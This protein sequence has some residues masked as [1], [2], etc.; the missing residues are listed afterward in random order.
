MHFPGGVRSLTAAQAPRWDRT[1]GTAVAPVR[2]IDRAGG[3][4]IRPVGRRRSLGLGRSARSIRAAE[5]RRGPAVAD[6][7]RHVRDTGGRR[8]PRHHR[9]V[10]R[11]SGRSR[12]HPSSRHVPFCLSRFLAR[13]PFGLPLTFFAPAPVLAH[14]M[15]PGS[16]FGSGLAQVGRISFVF[17]MGEVQIRAFPIGLTGPRAGLVAGSRPWCYVARRVRGGWGGT[18]GLLGVTERHGPESRG[19][20]SRG[21][22]SRDKMKNCVRVSNF[23]IGRGEGN[24]KGVGAAGHLTSLVTPRDEAWR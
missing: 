3:R 13:D 11:V 7:Q 17:G 22:I 15:G 16:A 6:R 24:R 19:S 5:G 10:E 9:R 18:T 20:A 14:S 2:G 12:P 1:F 21:R 23:L 8:W 4:V